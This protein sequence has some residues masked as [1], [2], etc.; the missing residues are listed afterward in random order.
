VIEARDAQRRKIVRGPRT[1]SVAQSETKLADFEREVKREMACHFKASDYT[2]NEIARRLGL[3]VN[4]IKKWFQEEEM[5]K[6]CAEI[7]KDM[8]GS[9]MNYARL[10]AFEMLDII[11]DVARTAEDDKTAITAACEYLDRIGMT[12]INKS[13]SLS[14]QTVKNQHEIVDR[15]GLLDALSENAP[16][17]V[18]HEV[19]EKL[20]QAFSLV[21]EHT[22]QDVTHNA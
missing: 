15:T 7:V 1:T 12:K 19:A 9:T 5:Q 11:A 18:L 17:E 14:T 4:T 8:V 3:G 13:E 6:R 10:N 21:A 22:E 20:D 16:P 2:Y